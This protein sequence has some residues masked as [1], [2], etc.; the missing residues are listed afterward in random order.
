MFNFV[1]NNVVF[2]V[3]NGWYHICWAF[4]K[5]EDRMH[6]SNIDRKN[7]LQF[8]EY[9]SLR[10]KSNLAIFEQWKLLKRK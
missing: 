8:Y 5:P 7:C 3:S 10:N 1:I 9:H 2:V 6:Y 4:L